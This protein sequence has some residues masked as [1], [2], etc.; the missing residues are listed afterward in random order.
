MLPLYGLLFW[1]CL[2]VMTRLIT[3]NDVIQ[4]AIT[5]LCIVSISPAKLTV[6]FLLLY[7]HSWDLPGAIFVIFQ[8][9]CHRFQWVEAHIQLHTQFTGHNP[10][11]RA[12]EMSKTL[13]ILGCDSCIQLSGKR[14][15][16]H[17][18]VATAEMHHLP[19]HYAHIC[20]LISIT[21]QQ[22][23]M[24]ANGCNCFC[25]EEFR[26]TPLFHTHFSVRCHSV[27]LPLCCHLS[28]GNN[29]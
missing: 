10:L 24:N 23:L 18:I 5:W 28:H 7:D 26:S 20:C 8:C 29:M 12:N 9:F 15:V 11:I 27:R 19:P 13:F 2:I 4:E 21:V 3:N 17:V 22:I 25:M 1:L 16:C 6:L 14:H